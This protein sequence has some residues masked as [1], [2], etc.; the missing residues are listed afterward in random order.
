MKKIITLLLILMSFGQAVVAQATFSKTASNPTGAILNTSIDT[1]TYSLTKGY[2]RVLFSCT[3]TRATGTGAGTAILDYRM[4]STDNWKSD[5]GDTL[6][7]T[8]VASQT[9]YWNKAVTA[10][11]WR[12]RVGGGTTVTA[13]VV[14]KLQTD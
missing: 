3:Y 1:S 13:T 9:H 11:H 14:A 12:I 2:D 10:R 7:I 4:S 6:T 8:N 5:A